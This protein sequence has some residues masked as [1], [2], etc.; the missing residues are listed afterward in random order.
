M[1]RVHRKIESHHE[2]KREKSSKQSSNKNNHRS[3]HE[4]KNKGEIISSWLDKLA[5]HLLHHVMFFLSF[6]W[7]RTRGNQIKCKFPRLSSLT[8]S[9]MK[10]LHSLIN[11][12]IHSMNEG[13]IVTF[14]SV[15][16]TVSLLPVHDLKRVLT[17]TPRVWGWGWSW[18]THTNL[19]W[20][21]RQLSSFCSSFRR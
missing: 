4:A 19:T 17:E 18:S 12:K 14:L 9:V 7:V 10:N 20:L 1:N 16:S 21:S 3:S 8:A 11:K 13:G 5:L 15:I 2:K 6:G